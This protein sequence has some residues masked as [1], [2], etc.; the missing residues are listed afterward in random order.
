MGKEPVIES[1][2]NAR[3][4]APDSETIFAEETYL[5]ERAQ[6]TSADKFKATLAAVPDSTP[7]D[8]DRY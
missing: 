3:F 5:K 4:P 1:S 7:E 6:R 2:G 8:F